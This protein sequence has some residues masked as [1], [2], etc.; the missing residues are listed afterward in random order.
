MCIWISTHLSALCLRAPLG[1]AAR[2]PP[3]IKTGEQGAFDSALEDV[4]A[5]IEGGAGPEALSLGFTALKEDAPFTLSLMAELLVTPALPAEKLE[6]IR[7]QAINSYMHRN[8]SLGPIPRREALK[9]TYGPDS[10][11]SRLLHRI[12]QDLA[13][14]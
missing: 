14:A 2:P 7:T 3:P 1:S 8:D 6:F 13:S 10:V 9:I 11:S 4:A 5:S 12:K